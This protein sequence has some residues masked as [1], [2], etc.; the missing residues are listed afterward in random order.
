MY[1][2][3]DVIIP[4]YNRAKYLKTALESLFEST[5][6]WRQTIILNNASTDNTLEVIEQ[7]KHQ[8]PNRVVKVITNSSNIG[9]AG[10]FKRTQEIAENEYT[11]IFHDDDVIHPEYVE[12]AMELMMKNSDAVIV[13]GGVVPQYNVNHENWDML[14]NTYLKYPSKDNAFYQLLVARAIFCTAIYKTSAYKSVTYQPEKYGKLHDIC[15]LMDVTQHG[16]LIFHQG[17]CG[18]WRQHSNSDSNTFSTGPFTNEVINILVH[19]Q[20]LTSVR[21]EEM[22]GLKKLLHNML[23]KTLIYNFSYFLY[24]WSLLSRFLEWDDFRSEMC[25]KGIFSKRDYWL[26]DRFID[27]IYNPQI[28]KKASQYFNSLCRSYDFRIGG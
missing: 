7:V 18:R 8:Y 11:A 23:V 9:N 28:R 13:V 10:N 21:T 27:S 2:N 16:S 14:P 3:L 22:K 25:D 20:E 17:I 1:Q 26:W 12:R 24:H 19:L 6:Q 15:F 5:A 4:T